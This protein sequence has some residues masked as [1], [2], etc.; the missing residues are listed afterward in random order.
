MNFKVKQFALAYF[1]YR[2]GSVI[3]YVGFEELSDQMPSM[4]FIL[5]AF[6]A[7]L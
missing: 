1:V 3:C 7:V 6:Y 2:A 5:F 4:P